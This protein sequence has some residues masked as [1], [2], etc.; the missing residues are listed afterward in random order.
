M[1]LRS[2]RGWVFK[3]ERPSAP[4][5]LRPARVQR[6]LRTRAQLA[7]NGSNAEASEP[8]LKLWRK[9]QAVCFDVDCE[10]SPG[11]QVARAQIADE[12][13]MRRGPR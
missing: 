9:T 3:S 1:H 4:R 13:Y 5:A 8:V 10:R 6:R 2:P 11:Q 12:H 7:N